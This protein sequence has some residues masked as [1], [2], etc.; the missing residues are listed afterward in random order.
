MRHLS[1]EREFIIYKHVG[2]SFYLHENKSVFFFALALLYLH[3]ER[4]P[5]TEVSMLFLQQLCLPIFS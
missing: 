3:L 1:A 5:F 2:I 4:V